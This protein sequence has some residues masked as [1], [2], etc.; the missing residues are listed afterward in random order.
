MRLGILRNQVTL[1]LSSGPLVP[2][3]LSCP[4]PAP[5]VLTSVCRT[6]DPVRTD[7]AKL[8]QSFQPARLRLML[9]RKPPKKYCGLA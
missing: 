3:V 4:I 2:P 1:W 6:P 8:V 5:P 9:S 7:M